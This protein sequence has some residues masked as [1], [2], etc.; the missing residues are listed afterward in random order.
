MHFSIFLGQGVTDASGDTRVIDLA[1]RQALYADEHGFAAVYCGEQYFNDVEPYA[2]G[3]MMSAY[4]AGQ[5]T[6][7]WVGLSV[8]ALVTHHPLVLA[9][10]INL[11]DQLTHGKCLIGFG[12]G[13]KGDGKPFHIA[14][15][16]PDERQALYDAK[17]EV[18]ER[19]LVHTDRG[20]PFLFDTGRESGEMGGRM[21]PAP[22]RR[23]PLLAIATN[24]PSK[25]AA[26]GRAGRFVQ[27]GPFAVPEAERMGRLYRDS[28]REGGFD[29]AYVA[30][31]MK[32]F[33]HTKM[34]FVADTDDEAW[35]FAE[36][37]LGGPMGLPPW[38]RP[39][40][41]ER[42][43]SLRE[44]FALDPGPYAHFGGPESISAFL[45]R[46]CLVGS[47]ETVAHQVA[48]YG[49]AGLPHL[50]VRFGIG[51]LDFAY[52]DRSLELFATEVMPK[53]GAEPV[54]GPGPDELRSV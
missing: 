54:P 48:A 29:E 12:V 27:V 7:A 53:V 33:T 24:T 18:L 4:L 35:E 26:A 8:V 11:L 37:A 5:L 41:Q 10:R 25:I 28:L 13:R 21:M 52:Y 22:F 46:M 49:E 6:Q 16:N 9:E 32:W 39:A 43:K 17:L 34:A 15:L 20:E 2:D 19:A 23:M 14:D 30:A 42:G 44:I 3:I 45:H 1:I 38:L 40:D 50:H 36:A 51:D 31:H 47:P